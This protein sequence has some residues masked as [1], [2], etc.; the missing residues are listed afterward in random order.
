IGV[1]VAGV[2]IL[3]GCMDDDALLAPRAG[4]GSIDGREILAVL[5]CRVQVGAGS[6]S[7]AAAE[8]QPPSGAAPAVLGGQR[9][10]VL[11]E[12]S[13][14]DYDSADEI[15]SVDVTVRSLLAL[16]I[17][18]SDGVSTDWDGVWV[19]CH[20]VGTPTPANSGPS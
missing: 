17:G 19:F 2:L 6:I 15:F 7:C 3:T 13:Y 11:L 4:D 20:D 8:P 1:A 18:T 12:S 10:S 14:P 16:P 9:I 5:D